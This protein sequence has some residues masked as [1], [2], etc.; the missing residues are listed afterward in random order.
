M[1]IVQ[2]PIVGRSSGKL[3]NVIFSKSYN[4][5]VLRSK[6]IEVR[7][8][9]STTQ[10]T[11]RAKFTAVQ[12]TIASL[13]SLVR[14]GYK[15]YQQDMSAYAYAMKKNLPEAIAGSYPNFTIDPAKLELSDGNLQ[16]FNTLAL[17][18]AS[19]DNAAFTWES[20]VDDETAH[21]SDTLN[22]VILSSTGVVKAARVNIG[23]RA[24]GSGSVDA[25]PGSSFVSGDVAL[26]FPTSTHNKA[27][28][29][30]ASK[31]KR[32]PVTF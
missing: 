2:N 13:L 25:N 19:A 12:T 31:V 29:D 5:N 10:L 27:G 20:D 11:Q 6:P 32:V 24:Q 7:D 28:A 26:L 22:V 17:E 1:A 18:D 3:A 23:T 8:K 15:G 4:K 9:K 16:Q 14:L 21:S 30:L